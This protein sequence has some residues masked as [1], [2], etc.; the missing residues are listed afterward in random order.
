M[1]SPPADEAKRLAW[2]SLREFIREQDDER[3]RLLG[4]WVSELEPEFVYSRMGAFA[5]VGITVAG[6]DKVLIYAKGWG[7]RLDR[8][9]WSLFP[10]TPSREKDAPF[11]WMG[12]DYGS[13]PATSINVTRRWSI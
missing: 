9:L 12:V 6:W 3:R 10:L 11:V 7:A 1:A 8:D 4:L 5:L 13:E 2:E